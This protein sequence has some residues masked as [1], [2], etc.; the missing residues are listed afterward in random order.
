MFDL[1]I[2][3]FSDLKEPAILWRL[4]VPFVAAIILVS[5]MGYGIFGVFIV[6]D[7]VT[8]NPFVTQ[9]GDWTEQAEQSIGSIPF[10][11]AAILWVLGLVFAVIAGVLG[12]LLGSYLILL[13]AMIITGFMTDSIV[14]AIHDK[15]YPHVD[16]QGHG[17]MLG[18]IGSMLWF[19]FLLLLLFIITIP[20]LF[21]PLV[22]IIW[23]WLLGFLFFRYSLVLDVGQVILPEN[24]FNEVKPISHWTPT[25]T[26]AALFLLS[27]MPLVGLF[28]PVLAVIALAHYYFDY[29][30][31]MSKQEDAEI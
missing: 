11:G 25:V 6:S 8:Q 5:L 16:Y 21:I 15:H 3:T 14:K 10:L 17:S 27:T 4:F 7:F 1:L 2:K 28:I 29:L 9:V 30:S 23:F 31:T 19:G 12:V 20:M 13:F 26:L 18:M 24:L 22:N